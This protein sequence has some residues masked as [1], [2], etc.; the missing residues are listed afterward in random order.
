MGIQLRRGY[1]R[2]LRLLTGWFRTAHN[3]FVEVVVRRPRS[4]HG[5]DPENGDQG[6]GAG[7]WIKPR[8]R[9]KAGYR[10]LGLPSVDMLRC[11]R[12][13][14]VPNKW[15]VV[16]TSPTGLLRDPSN[17][18]ADLR[19]VFQRVGYTW[20]TSHVFRKTAATLLDDAEVT[21]RKIAD[22][23]GQAQVSVTQNYYLGRKIGSE[24]A[25]RVLE[26]IG[27]PDAAAPDCWSR[28]PETPV[29]AQ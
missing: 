13:E 16:F 26:I 3:A 7:P 14:A 9:S 27:R 28:Q 29:D 17:T 10:K 23:L 1:I 4:G 6:E 21:A 8:P 15:D 18:Q 12:Q 19:D 20:V 24:E 2:G 5:R 25:A 22:Q 11:R